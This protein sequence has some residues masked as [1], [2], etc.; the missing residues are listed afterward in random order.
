MKTMLI[1]LAAGAALLG[2]LVTAEAMPGAMPVA[3]SPAGEITLVSGGC[4]FGAHRG[5][6]GRCRANLYRGYGYRRY[7][8]RRGYFRNF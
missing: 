7:G 8:Y 4:G 6:Y 5:Y 3:G 2:G 1:S